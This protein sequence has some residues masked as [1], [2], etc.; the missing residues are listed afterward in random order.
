MTKNFVSIDS[1]VDASIARGI[2][3]AEQSGEMEHYLKRLD[4]SLDNKYNGGFFAGQIRWRDTFTSSS[5]NTLLGDINKERQV[6]TLI[7]SMLRK[8][9]FLN[10]TAKPE[11]RESP[12]ELGLKF[13]LAVALFPLALGGCGEEHDY[14]DCI[15]P[16]EPCPAGDV[17]CWDDGDFEHCE[18]APM[19]YETC[20]RYGCYCIENY[21][22]GPNDYGP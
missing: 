18:C 10:G 21:P 9:I 6:K 1:V 11:G 14:H 2:A 15:D 5:K 16:D 20:D 7:N 12:L 3:T 22:D 4:I 17:R 8:N 19:N 13:M